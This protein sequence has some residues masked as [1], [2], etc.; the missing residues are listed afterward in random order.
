[1]LLLLRVT[2]HRCIQWWL[3]TPIQPPVENFDSIERWLVI[4]FN[5]L[6]LCIL[7]FDLGGK[8]NEEISPSLMNG[9]A[10]AAGGFCIPAGVV[11]PNLVALPPETSSS[12]TTITSSYDATKSQPQVSHFK[13]SSSVPSSPTGEI[14]LKTM[15]MTLTMFIYL[16][17]TRGLLQKIWFHR[18]SCSPLA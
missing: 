8:T 15:F 3:F 6:Q 12:A 1:M 11:I 2:L 9:T 17:F 5:L 7:C 14:W 13:H 4:I 16:F 10:T 18:S